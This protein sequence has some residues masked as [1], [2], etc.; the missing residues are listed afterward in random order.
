MMRGVEQIKGDS[1]LFTA[2]LPVAMMPARTGGGQSPFICEAS[3]LEPINRDC[4]LPQYA[5]NV[6]T[7]STARNR[8]LSLFIGGG[9]SA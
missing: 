1:P 8:G 9:R 4:P 5:R 2:G 7:A 3:V 6:R